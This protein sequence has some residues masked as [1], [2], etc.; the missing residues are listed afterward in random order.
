LSV[1]DS[2]IVPLME[3]DRAAQVLRDEY[4]RAAGVEPKLIVHLPSGEAQRAMP[5]A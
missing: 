2:V 4:R 5:A 3:Q 1:H